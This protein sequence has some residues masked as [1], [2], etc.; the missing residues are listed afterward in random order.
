MLYKDFYKETPLP[1]DIQ[2]YILDFKG[3]PKKEGDK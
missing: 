2:V 1:I 3:E